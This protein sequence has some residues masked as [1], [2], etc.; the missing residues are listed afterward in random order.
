MSYFDH[1]AESPSTAIGS[2]ITRRTKQRELALMRPFFSSRDCAILEIGPGM[3]GSAALFAE[4]GYH[5]YAVVE[6]NPIMREHLARKGFITKDYMI[7]ELAE[8]DSSY[9]AIVLINVFE[10]LNSSREAQTFI[11]EARRV[12]RPGGI[13]CMA[14]PDY[15]HWQGDF[16]NCDFSHSN[17]TS[18]RRTLQLFHNNGF[19]TL[20]C[21]YFSGFFSGTLATLISHLTRIA[22]CAANSNGMDKKLYKLKLTFL[23]RFF[24]I[25]A[26]Q[27]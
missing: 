2:W 25:A 16:F 18:V 13:V 19:R 21:V 12:L 7:P 24:I 11:A 26:R 14:S 5:N 6:P 8:Q 3:G 15:L 4:A 22:L 23:R 10:H 9:D 17:V 27:A 20:K 1:F